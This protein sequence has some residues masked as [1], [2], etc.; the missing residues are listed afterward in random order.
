VFADNDPALALYRGL[1]FELS[2]EPGPDMI[3]VG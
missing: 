3:L 2:G 1:G